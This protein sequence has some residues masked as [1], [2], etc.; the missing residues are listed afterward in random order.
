LETD[1][2]EGNRITEKGTKNVGS[3]NFRG[4]GEIVHADWGRKVAELETTTS[5]KKKGG[6]RRGN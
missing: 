1:A 6:C 4:E 3:Y 5:V 2:I